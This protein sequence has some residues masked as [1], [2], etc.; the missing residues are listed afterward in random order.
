MLQL[1]QPIDMAG[2][3]EDGTSKMEDRSLANQIEDDIQR[4][5]TAYDSNRK[6]PSAVMEARFVFVLA[7]QIEDNIQRALTSYESNR[8]ILSVMEAGFVYHTEIWFVVLILKAV[9]WRFNIR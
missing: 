8:K 7:N 1:Q 5:L 9:W 3:Y 6:I 2:L 4:A